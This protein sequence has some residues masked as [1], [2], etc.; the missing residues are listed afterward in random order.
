MTMRTT[1]PLELGVGEEQGGGGEAVAALKKWAF[2]RYVPQE[3]RTRES[4]RVFW[5]GEPRFMCF[6]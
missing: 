4:L 6:L 5:Y 3:N 2:H 1:W